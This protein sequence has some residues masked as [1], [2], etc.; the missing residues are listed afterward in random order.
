[1]GPIGPKEGEGGVLGSGVFELR[2]AVRG[3]GMTANLLRR[4]HRLERTG[5]HLRGARTVYVVGR[6]RFEQLRVREDDPQLVVQAMEQDPE[7]RRFFH[8]ASREELLAAPTGHQAWFRCS[9]CHAA[10]DDAGRSG[11]FGSRQSV[12]TKMRTEP[13]AV[14][15]YSILPD[16]SQ[17]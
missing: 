12:S 11:R 14:R 17:L 10:V 1:M 2:G 15:T 6:F 4:P 8:G 3:A 13:P 16:E 7:L 5:H 9:S